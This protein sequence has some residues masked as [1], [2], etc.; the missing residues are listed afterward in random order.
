V[1]LMLLLN[2]EPLGNLA[3]K[4]FKVVSFIKHL[5]YLHA[6]IT[7]KNVV[8]GWLAYLF[9]SFL[10]YPAFENLQQKVKNPKWAIEAHIEL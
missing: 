2:R 3:S 10:M 4:H 6:P 9:N 7:L 1:F 8:L 5:S